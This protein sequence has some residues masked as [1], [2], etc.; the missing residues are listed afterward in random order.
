MVYVFDNWRIDT[1]SREAWQ[2][3]QAVALPRRVFDLVVYLIAQRARA[4][5]RDELVAAVWGRVDVADVQVSQL[6]A[7][8]R[9]LLG[10]DAQAQAAIRTVAGFGY[11]WAMPVVEA[12]AGIAGGSVA[13]VDAAAAL[14]IAAATQAVAVTAQDPPSQQPPPQQLPQPNPQPQLLSPTQSSG[15]A[16]PASASLQ[17][18]RRALLGGLLAAVLL[19]AIGMSLLRSSHAP[20][21]AVAADRAQVAL[22]VLPVDVDGPAEADWVRLG[23]M[24]LVAGRLRGAG[25]AVLPSESVLA[26]QRQ[27]G[28]D[29]AGRSDLARLQQVLGTPRQVQ[30]QA[31]K[32]AAGWRIALQAPDSGGV[33]RR[34]ETERADVVEA[35]RAAA[36]LLLAVLGAAPP[37][38]SAQE[39][40]PEALIPRSQAAIL[41]GQF[42]LARSIL[43][44]AAPDR[45]SQARVQLQ[46]AHIDYAR[47]Q[48]DSAQQQLEQL[49]AQDLEPSLR[50]RA[51][52]SRG[53]LAVRRGDCAAAE[54]AFSGALQGEPDVAATA[55]A[56]RG[57]AR[58]C[59][60]RPAEAMED[61][62]LAR[63]RLEAAGD[64]L[65]MARVDNYLG[66]AAV[67]RDRLQDA[68]GHFNAARSV[69]HEFGIPDAQRA[70]L[71]A[72]LDTHVHLLRWDEALADAEQLQQLRAQVA[73]PAQRQILDSDRARVLV[74]RGRFREATEILDAAG[75]TPA[76]PAARRFLGAVRAELAWRQERG[77]AARTAALDA[78]ADWPAR[79]A[80]VRRA[81]LLLL[82]QRAGGGIATLAPAPATLDDNAAGL[83]LLRLAAAEAAGEASAEAAYAQALASADAR[84]IPAVLAAVT[85]SYA[86]WLLAHGRVDEAAALSVRL[87]TCAATDFDCARLRV[88]LFHARRERNAWAASLAH[89][90]E[91]AGERPIAA[92]LQ[93]EP[94]SGP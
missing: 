13:A 83:P 33:Q 43:D 84:G 88:A 81:A 9:R 31:F 5:G 48:L 74:G 78:L 28:R 71:S 17:R 87:Q 82:L 2:G 34:V 91:L 20:P 16:V 22:A 94:G 35:G 72:L 79:A 42:E 65:G 73:D 1:A 15:G 46:R 63:L 53:M 21:Q 45:R 36:D 92:A 4:V 6:I 39:A 18:R 58:S 27:A 14:P 80:D 10:D 90:R 86:Q 47:G 52:A 19:L 64:R 24:D 44:A 49:L 37:A 25:L 59:L 29:K 7:R 38:G 26:A 30:A 60:E 54:Q 85:V 40:A 56:G 70:V 51:L 50:A 75:P 69:F 55:L 23:L 93:E 57:L 32:T 12:A 11:R 76:S 66:I 62:G 8:A 41:A 61:L 77:D 68:L 89:L 3:A 67:S